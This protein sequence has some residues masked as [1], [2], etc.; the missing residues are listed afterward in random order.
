LPDII[1]APAAPAAAAP[2]PEPIAPA[3]APG[4]GAPAPDAGGLDSAQTAAFQELLKSN[5]A[6]A[7]ETQRYSSLLGR[8]SAID[9]V[10]KDKLTDQEI[11]TLVTQ[12]LTATQQPGNGNGAPKPDQAT[13]KPTEA[14]V[15]ARIAE[16]V[17]KGRADQDKAHAAALREQTALATEAQATHAKSR[18]D[19]ALRAACDR[20]GGLRSDAVILAHG[21]DEGPWRLRCKAD[22]QNPA[23]EDALEVVGTDGEPVYDESKGVRITPA[24]YFTKLREQRPWI[25]GPAPAMTG[26][27]GGPGARGPSGQPARHGGSLEERLSQ[28]WKEQG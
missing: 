2:P 12:G 6:L 10:D 23:A 9:G 26:G 21:A 4:N 20:I 11:V 22:A 8:L 25:V 3:P 27:G 19:L 16:A 5:Q 28:A 13:A 18:D 1:P 24:A 14:D 7:A 17:R 15:E